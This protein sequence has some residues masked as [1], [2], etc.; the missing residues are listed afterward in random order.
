MRWAL[1]LVLVASSASAQPAGVRERAGAAFA[2]AERAF[3]EADY[4]EALRLFRD[5]FTTLP[6]DRVRFNIAVCL[7][8]LGRFREAG[9][10]YDA[11]ATSSTLD[12]NVRE[13]A[14]VEAERVR[15]RLGKLVVEGA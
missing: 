5:A 11:A 9:I 12:P 14:R 10:E 6:D 1:A 7:E 4:P 13:R 15:G 2:D 3:N 8:R